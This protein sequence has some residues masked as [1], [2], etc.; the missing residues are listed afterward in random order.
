MLTSSHKTNP[1]ISYFWIIGRG[2]RH[3]DVLS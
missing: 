1:I 3:P 2:N